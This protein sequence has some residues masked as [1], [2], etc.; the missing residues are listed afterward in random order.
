R[1]N[2]D[3]HASRRRLLQR[4][5][6]GVLRL[7]IHLL[8]RCD[9]RHVA[10]AFQRTHRKP[11]LQRADLLHADL[12]G[13]RAGEVRLGG[14]AAGD[15]LL[16]RHH[17]GYVRMTPARDAQAGGALTAG[18]LRP[19]AAGQRLSKANRGHL[20]SDP[21]RA[22]EQVGVVHRLRRQRG[23]KGPYCSRLSMDCGQ[24]HGASMSGRRCGVNR[25]REV[26]PA[27]D[28]RAA[29]TAVLQVSAECGGS[30]VSGE[31]TVTVVEPSEEEEG[32]RLGIPE[33]KLVSDPGALWRSRTAGAT[34]EINDAHEDYLAL[35][36]D[37]RARLR[38]LLALLAKE[39]VE[40]S[41]G[42]PGS[43]TL[44]ERMGDIPALA[45]RTRRSF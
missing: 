25:S 5:Q 15:H 16:L 6:E 20:L 26:V 24:S 13:R 32:I 45:E 43:G 14:Q 29:A 40:R 28:A 4:L 23:A 38:Y 42:Q 9:D 10:L 12:A 21:L 33:P 1:G 27:P 8:S 7:S 18:F 17:P 22:G 3:Q 36:S 31:A 2:Q 30:V 44:L 41:Y 19:L 37:S 11:L 35:R 34:W 39:I